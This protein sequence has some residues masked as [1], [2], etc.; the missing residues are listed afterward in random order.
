MLLSSSYHCRI[1]LIDVAAE[2]GLSL[3]L[4]K[5]SLSSIASLTRGDISVTES[6]DLLYS[7]PALSKVLWQ[8]IPSVTGMFIGDDG[9][10]VGFVTANFTL[11][12][13]ST[14]ISL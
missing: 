11:L 10:G 7:S 9:S 12:Y 2:A 1:L 5:Q 4:T 6:G 14:H 13:R 8:A 3:S